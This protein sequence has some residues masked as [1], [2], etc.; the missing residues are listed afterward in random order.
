MW[1]QTALRI[2]HIDVC[3][4][5]GEGMDFG[6]GTWGF[7]DRHDAAAAATDNQRRMGANAMFLGRQV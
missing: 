7:G 1:D 2:G 6:C 4:V 5:A 3:G